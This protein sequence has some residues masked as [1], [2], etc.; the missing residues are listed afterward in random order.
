MKSSLYRCR[1]M[2]HRLSPTVHRFEHNVHMFCLDLDE[3]DHICS[4]N[5]LIRRNHF[6]L[7][8]FYDRDHLPM[9]GDSDV[10]TNLLSQLSERGVSLPPDTRVILVTS[11]RML[12]YVFNPVSFYFCFSTD[13]TP[14]CAV[15]EV[16]NTFREMKMFVLPGAPVN[17]VYTG[18]QRKDFYVSPYFDVEDEFEFK[19]RVPNERLAIQINTRR[20]AGKLMLSTLTGNQL[21]LSVRNV[22]LLTLEIPFVTLKVITLIH[23]HALLLWLKRIPIHWKTEKLKSQKDVFNPHATLEVKK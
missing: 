12:G 21:P 8:S 2:H 23:W 13:G 16:S 5:P 9:K 15:A 6:G 10:K 3:I 19:L 20:P 4:I 22:I 1:I 11:L 7:Y 17:G 18:Q 14:V